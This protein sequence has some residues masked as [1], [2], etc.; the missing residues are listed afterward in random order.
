MKVLKRLDLSAEEAQLRLVMHLKKTGDTAEYQAAVDT[1]HHMLAVKTLEYYGADGYDAFFERH[2]LDYMTP[3][4]YTVAVR[5][6][7]MTICIETDVGKVTGSGSTWDYLTD[8]L[9]Y[10]VRPQAM[11]KGAY[12]DI[13]KRMAAIQD[14]ERVLYPFHPLH[15]IGHGY[16]DTAIC[17]YRAHA[18]LADK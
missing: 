9:V 14:N 17:M 3:D 11:D 16:F 18:L 12:T 6:H 10:S 15:H 5:G 13:K 2:C 1:L 4:G 8:D 7:D